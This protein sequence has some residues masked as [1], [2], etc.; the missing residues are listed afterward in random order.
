MPDR[1]QTFL[2][3]DHSLPLA[4][5]AEERISAVSSRLILQ[6]LHFCNVLHPEMLSE[7]AQYCRFGMC[8]VISRFHHR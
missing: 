3:P 8:F 5:D 7:M 4:F 2:G 1:F 6:S